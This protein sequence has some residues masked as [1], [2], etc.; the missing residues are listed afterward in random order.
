MGTLG[1]LLLQKKDRV[2][3]PM[4]FRRAALSRSLRS[5]LAHKLIEFSKQVIGKPYPPRGFLPF[6]AKL[7]AA[8]KGAGSCSVI[9]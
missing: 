7:T 2:K 9:I 1:F 6:L 3:V 4:R 8:I 5:P